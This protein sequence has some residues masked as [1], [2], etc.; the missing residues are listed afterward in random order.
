MP[1]GLPQTVTVAE[2]GTGAKTAS[3]ARTNFSVPHLT[4]V[5]ADA[6][7]SGEAGDIA[8]DATHFYACIGTDTWVRTTLAT[9]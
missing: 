9:W 6:S 3:A 4:T 7:D 5:P 1:T 8:Y 2:G